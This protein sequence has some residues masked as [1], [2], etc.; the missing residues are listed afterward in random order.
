MSTNRYCTSCGTKHTVSL[1]PVKFCSSCGTPFEAVASTQTQQQ[2]T[3]PQTASN[4]VEDHDSEDFEL[5][6]INASDFIIERP[7]KLTVQ[8]I[9]N[10]PGAGGGDR[11]DASSPKLTPEQAKANF[12]ALFSKERDANS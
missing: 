9:R 3:K 11:G 6:Q 5:P 8:D 4:V 10:S 7:K 1:K 2:A 12:A